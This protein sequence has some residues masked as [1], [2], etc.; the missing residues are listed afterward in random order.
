MEIIDFHTHV[1]PEKIAE[2]ATQT[3]CQSYHLQTNLVGTTKIL[4]QEGRKANISSFVLLPV[5]VKPEQ[6][7]HINLFMLEEMHTHE[8][9][10]SFGGIH[11]GMENL[12]E[13]V[14]FIQK[15]GLKG[16]KLH[17]DIQE[18]AIDDPRLFP[19]YDQIQGKLPVLIHCGDPK[20]NY[21][22]PERL[23]RILALF[24]HL[25]VIA[26]HLG[27]W[28]IFDTALTYLRNTS[29]FLDLS[30]CFPFLP[31]EK[32]ETYISCYG[33]ERILFG[34]DFPL[35]S[36]EQEVNHFLQ[37]HLPEKDKE[38]I[39]FRNAREILNQ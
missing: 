4:L 31:M 27:G 1:Y 28:S 18:T 33:A 29:C 11:A 15:S 9:F 25:Q 3:T 30:S 21:S 37:L 12:S 16:I 35:W 8:E 17:P 10:Y 20:K 32:I 26:A 5:V 6:A 13:E 38:K 34:T 22:H 24:P 39:A 19:V 36:P 23:K 7:R 2:K 14:E